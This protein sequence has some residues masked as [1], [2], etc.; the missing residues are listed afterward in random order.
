M[1]T[2]HP[3][4][5]HGTA[6][7]KPIPP[8]SLRQ[9]WQN[10][11]SHRPLPWCHQTSACSVLGRQHTD[12]RYTL[13]LSHPGSVCSGS[14]L[15]HHC[16]HCRTTEHVSLAHTATAPELQAL[17]SSLQQLPSS[18][19]H[20]VINFFYAEAFKAPGNGDLGH[21]DNL[22]LSASKS[23]GQRD[24]NPQQARAN[25]TVLGAVA[26]GEL[27]S[28]QSHGAG[29]LSPSQPCAPW[30]LRAP[31]VWKRICPPESPQPLT[32]HTTGGGQSVNLL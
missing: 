9:G 20:F 21:G 25:L 1:R 11:D 7:G 8:S 2:E 15:I 14:S 24:G 17:P 23:H 28:V 26:L 29:T 16:Q 27:G 12:P 32:A 10:P 5:P 13:V 4:K 19:I 6:R 3:F 22:Q 31:W 18:T 30:G